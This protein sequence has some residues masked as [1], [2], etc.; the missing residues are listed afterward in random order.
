VAE[1]VPVGHGSVATYPDRP[2]L[3]WDYTT[4]YGQQVTRNNAVDYLEACEELHKFFGIFAQDNPAYQDPAGPCAWDSIKGPVKNILVQEKT[5]NDRIDLWKNAI[6][7][8]A[9]FQSAAEDKD[10]S[11]TCYDWGGSC[12]IPHFDGIANLQDCDSYLFLRAAVQYRN[13]VL[14]EM[15]PKVRL[16]V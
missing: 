3:N 8:G 7:S 12:T 11:Y 16:S 14:Y 15:L 13:F 5:E 4:E 2:Y 9:L 10:L 1:T 6:A